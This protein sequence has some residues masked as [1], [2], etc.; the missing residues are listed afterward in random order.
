MALDRKILVSIVGIFNINYGIKFRQKR[1]ITHMARPKVNDKLKQVPVPVR[2]SLIDKLGKETI[3]K[4]LKQY[5]KNQ[6][7]SQS[8]HLPG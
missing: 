6:Y 8:E 5:L 7:A 4:D 2:Q 3:I 1:F